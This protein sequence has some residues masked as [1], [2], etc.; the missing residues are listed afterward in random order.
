MKDTIVIQKTLIKGP[1]YCV[2]LSPEATT[3]VKRICEQTGLSAR[4]VASTIIVQA[5]NKGL[6]FVE[7]DE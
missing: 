4:S 7:E 3:I 1:N 6:L 5:E 2:A